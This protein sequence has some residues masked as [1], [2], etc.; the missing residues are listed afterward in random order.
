M[1][2]TAIYGGTFDPVTYGHLD[3]VKRG[4]G[5]FDNFIIAVAESKNKNP[6]FTLEERIEILK[7]V[8][9][10]IPGVEVTGFNGLL[11]DYARS[12]GATVVLRGLRAVSDFEYEFQMAL[13]NR[14]LDE[15]IE[16][17]FMMPR[18]E[19]SYMSSRILKE[20]VRLGADVS[21]FVPPSVK[22]KL[23]EKLIAKS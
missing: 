18:E 20:I 2:V 9:K 11:V 17:I 6:L 13:T 5:I 12:R 7:E 22:K 15:H 16:T 1:K 3:L 8:I 21:C 10:D 4:N 23:E 19:H 14:K